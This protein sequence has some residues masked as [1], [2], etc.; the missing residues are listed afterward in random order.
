MTLAEFWPQCLRLLFAELN[1]QQFN[2]AIAPLTVGEEAGSWVIYSKNQFII[3]LLRSQYAKRLYQLQHQIAPD[4]PLF[5]FKIGIGQH[6]NI[7]H[8]LKVTTTTANSK[9]K[10]KRKKQSHK[11]PITTTPAIQH[12]HNK[13]NALGSNVLNLFNINENKNLT[14]PI[15][16]SANNDIKPTK[17]QKNC[18][19]SELTP[20]SS[21][22]IEPNNQID[23]PI[24]IENSNHTQQPEH[25]SS[26]ISAQDIISKRLKNLHLKNHKHNE[27]K[28]IHAP[29]STHVLT[30][31]NTSQATQPK[32][33]SKLLKD[34]TNLS[35]EYSFDMLVEGEGNRVAVAMA[36]NISENLGEDMYNPFFVYGS[37]G[38]GKTHLV[39]AIGNKVLHTNPKLKVCYMHSDEYIKTFMH[40]VRN[41]NWESFKQKYQ[42]YNL[43]IID[44]IQFIQGKDRTM[45]EFLFLFEYFHNHNQQIILTCDRLPNTLENMEKRLISRFSW[46]VAIKLEPPEL[47]M[48]IHILERKA[49]AAGMHLHSDAAFFIAQNVKQNVRE[50]EG[51]LNRVLA[52]CRFEQRKI[53]DMDA[54]TTALEDIVIAS[55]HKPITVELI[56]KTVADYYH[57]RIADLLGQKRL[58]T[59]ARPRQIAMSITKELTN[60]SSPNIGEAF[61][62]R[63]H[64][65]VLHALKTIEKLRIQ[66]ADLAQD[67]EKLLVLARN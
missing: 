13:K 28:N 17:K 47:E 26:T 46:G 50:L 19:Q 12:N 25:N 27:E 10:N 37:T 22:T 23:I 9:L 40:T 29:Q 3:N 61:G 33:K 53:I 49:H 32:Q 34:N 65:T 60:M 20:A 4:S 67:Y 18:T 58:R 11:L 57:I 42:Q 39:Q 14:Q 55:N 6:Y 66:N 45:E 16:M 36:K 31:S 21:I 5:Q 56:M 30:T 64:S 54:V 59:I 7:A 48:R 51:A 2:M 43:L 38:L 15:A 41:K 35:P 8:P 1:E 52:R 63:D 62:G 24:T 44:D